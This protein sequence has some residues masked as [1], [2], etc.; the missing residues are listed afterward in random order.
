[1]QVRVYQQGSNRKDTLLIREA[2]VQMLSRLL[3]PEQTEQVNLQV[4]VTKLDG[5]FGDIELQAAPYFRLR[6]ADDLNSILTLVTLAHELVHLAQVVEGRLSLS[7]QPSGTVWHWDGVPYGTDPYDLEDVK[8]PWEVDA[9]EREGDLACHFV[10]E[11]VRN[12]NA[13]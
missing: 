9:L 5:D 11:Y 13:A 7:S 2:A 3:K 8:L 1:M 10:N 12:L 4:L 6:L